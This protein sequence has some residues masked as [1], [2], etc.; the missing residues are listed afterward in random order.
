MRGLARHISKPTGQEGLTLVEV[1]I[2]I[3]ILTIGLL[4]VASMQI[5]AINSNSF[6]NRVTVATNL[7][8]EK[9]EDL[10]AL[11]YTTAFLDPALVGGGPYSEPDS[12]PGYTITWQ[13]VDDSPVAN[14]KRIDVKVTWVDKGVTKNSTLSCIKSRS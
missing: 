7:A 12:L 6:A 3:S 1:I 4:A 9:L 10:M 11:P 2:A 14:S 8:Q 5:M 13:V